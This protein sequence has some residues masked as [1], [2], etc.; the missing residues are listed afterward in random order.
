MYIF[1]TKKSIFTIKPA[2]SVSGTTLHDQI[3]TLDPH[4]PHRAV[5]NVHPL[6]IESI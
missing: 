1:L 2:K 3:H 6:R 5:N 4:T